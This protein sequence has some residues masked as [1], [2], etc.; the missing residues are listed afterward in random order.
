MSTAPP[1]TV[2]SRVRHVDGYSGTIRYA[3]PLLHQPP[4]SQTTSQEAQWYGVE[5]DEDGHG[6][7]NG[8]VQGKTY[9]TC[10]AGRG[11]LLKPDRFQS[12]VS[13][14]EALVLRYTEDYNVEELAA[15]G[16]RCSTHG[17]DPFIRDSLTGA[18]PN[19]KQNR[20]KL[21]RLRR[22]GTLVKSPHCRNHGEFGILST[23]RRSF[24]WPP[25]VQMQHLV[26]HLLVA[27]LVVV[28]LMGTPLRNSDA[29]PKFATMLKTRTKKKTWKTVHF[30]ASNLPKLLSLNVSDTHLGQLDFEH[31]RELLGTAWSSTLTT[32]SANHVG[33]DLLTLS[34]LLGSF[35]AISEVNFGRN[36][37]GK[38]DL[39]DFSATWASADHAAVKQRAGRVGWTVLERLHLEKTAVM[40]V[41][42]LQSWFLLMKEDSLEERS[43]ALRHLNLSDN[44][45][46]SIATL[47]ATVFSRTTSLWMR[48][49]NFASWDVCAQE[50]LVTFPSLTDLIFSDDAL[51]EASVPKDANESSMNG[52]TQQRITA[53]DGMPSYGSQFD[54]SSLERFRFMTAV[55]PRQLQRLNNSTLTD[56]EWAAA[57]RMALHMFLKPYV[58]FL[59]NTDSNPDRLHPKPADLGANVPVNVHAIVAKHVKEQE[60][61]GGVKIFVPKPRFKRDEYGLHVVFTS[62]SFDEMCNVRRETGFEG[63]V[64]D[65]LSALG[66]GSKKSTSSLQL[67]ID[68]LNAVGAIK[69]P[70]KTVVDVRW[71]VQRLRQHLVDHMELEDRVVDPLLNFAHDEDHWTAA[72]YALI[73]LS[74]PI[75]SE[76]SRARS[77]KLRSHLPVPL[78]RIFPQGS[79]VLFHYDMELAANEGATEKGLHCKHLVRPSDKLYE[80]R[81]SDGDAIVVVMVS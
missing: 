67:D 26:P 4:P 49:A 63:L 61:L 12:N 79:L 10:P 16:R 37:L 30:I 72:E 42:F 21:R 17:A 77:A 65:H 1:P 38:A 57:E 53:D 51:A 11:S 43:T 19:V 50:L 8:T 31:C 7:N 78:K 76:E 59:D 41:A 15:R 75:L 24:E 5:W 44:K 36:D 9:F 60:K 20:S 2:G 54:Q 39:N 45:V 23:T 68:A 27:C 71:T 48:G 62:I 70:R 73:S 81:I 3:G 25:L 56:R 66:I 74:L 52:R 18:F 80:H 47:S 14:L 58:S 69:D 64:R 40:D 46:R 33:G 34:L 35:D 32:L 6:K 28:L 55:F 29:S 22:Q 13:L